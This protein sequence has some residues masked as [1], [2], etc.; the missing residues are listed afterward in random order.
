MSKLPIL[1]NL[2]K[3]LILVLGADHEEFWISNRI[4]IGI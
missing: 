2:E 4:S 3:K 1:T